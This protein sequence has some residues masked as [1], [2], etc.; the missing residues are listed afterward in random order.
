MLTWLAEAYAKLGRSVDG[1]N[2][3]AEAEQIIAATE[4]RGGEGMLHRVRGDLLY[5]MGDRAGAEQ[6]YD[7]ALA[8]AARQSAK[9][10]MRGA[11]SLARLWRDQGKRTEARDLLVPIYGWFTE[12]FDTPVLQHAKALLDELA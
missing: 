4:E 7:R 10:T 5:T 8:V 3:L 12:G 2:C 11:T 9:P 6:S 1:M